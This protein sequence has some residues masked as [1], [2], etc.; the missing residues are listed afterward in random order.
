MASTPMCS[1]LDADRIPE[2]AAEIE[3]SEEAKAVLRFTRQVE[4]TLGARLP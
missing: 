4:P 3:G 2:C 1:R